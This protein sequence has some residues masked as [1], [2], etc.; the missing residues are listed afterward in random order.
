MARAG[1]T[2]PTD[3]DAARHWRVEPADVHVE[4]PLSAADPD[5]SVVIAT[6]PDND[7]EEVVARL[8]DQVV[9]ADWEVIVV[10]DDAVDRCEARNVGLR[11]ADGEIVAFTDDDTEPP[12][13]WLAGVLDAFRSTPELV[14]LEGRVTGGPRYTGRGHYVGCNMAVRREAALA[15]GGWDPRFAGWREDT[16]FGWRLEATA[17]GV[18]EYRD[19]VHMVH[20]PLPR[21][22]YDPEHEQ[23]LRAEYP[24]RYADRVATDVVRRGWRVLQQFGLAPW[25]SRVRR[26][27]PRP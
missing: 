25:I 16:E 7:H 14:C 1:E 4:W 9:E 17:D 15:V 18:C 12:P 26:A 3:P 10:N 23:L 20:P 13:D 6:V 27:L 19:E 24:E 21:T 2:G 11:V 8:R 22:N 5:V